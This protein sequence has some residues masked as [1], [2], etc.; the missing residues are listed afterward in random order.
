MKQ[1]IFKLLIAIAGLLVS[2]NAFAYDFKVDGICYNITSSEDRT[3]EVTYYD[4]IGNYFNF[5]TKYVGDI[6]IPPKVISNS[7]TYSV[8]SIRHSAF[9]ECTGLTS[10]SI[11]NSV[12]SIGN[13]AF[14]ECTGL[15]SVAIP[16]SVTSIGDYAFSYCHSLTSVTIPN[17]VT[18]IGES[19][20]S[21][22]I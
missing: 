20:F 4:K 9:R 5:Y 13:F 12:T 1:L 22:C 10:V 21:S 17:S 3:V 6:S 8:T 7:I 19:A 16:N 11:P 15:T 18:S 14:R 2:A